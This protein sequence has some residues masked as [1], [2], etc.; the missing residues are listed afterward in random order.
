MSRAFLKDET[1]GERP[2]IPPRPALPPNTPNYVTPRGLEQLRAELVELEA[3]RSRTE[4]NRDD[5]A[6]RTRQLTIINGRLSELMSRISSAKVVDIKNQPQ[7]EVRFGATVTLKTISGGKPGTIRKFTIVG[8]DE[9]SVPE[10]KIAFIAP[11]AR[12]VQEAK[13]GEKITLKLGRTE[14]IVE[15]K[16]IAYN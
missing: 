4:A 6:S 12:A 15:V 13:P 1:S 2:V 11:I 14:E 9:A 3:E 10:G 7:D 8:V 16:E 5:A